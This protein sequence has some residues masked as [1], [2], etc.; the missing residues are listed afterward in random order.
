MKRLEG[1]IKVGKAIALA[2]IISLASCASL[3]Q[4]IEPKIGVVIP[5]STEKDNPYNPIGTGGVE[6]W[7]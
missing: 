4:Y 6:L 2:G 3:K 1:I 5:I 7:F